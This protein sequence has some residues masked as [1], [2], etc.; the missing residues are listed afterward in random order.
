MSQHLG[1]DHADIDEMLGAV[2]TIKMIDQQ[3]AQLRLRERLNVIIPPVLMFLVFVSAACFIFA[4]LT[5]VQSSFDDTRI[6]L[7]AQRVVS[8]AETQ[9]IARDQKIVKFLCDDLAYQDQWRDGL[10]RAENRFRPPTSDPYYIS[11]DNAFNT[12]AQHALNRQKACA[13]LLSE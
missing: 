1:S 8:Q 12:M 10:H 6:R 5:A 9:E 11:R 7:D 4:R 3:G 13:V 2:G